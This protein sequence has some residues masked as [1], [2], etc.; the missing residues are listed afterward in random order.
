MFNEEAPEA[1]PVEGQEGREETPAQEET[2]E[3]EVQYNKEPYKFTSKDD[4]IAAAQKG[5]NYDK[6]L[7]QLTEAEKK[8]QF[9]DDL[10]KRNGFESFEAYQKAS[11]EYEQKKQV[12]DLVKQGIS[13]ELAQR[14]LQTETK[15]SEMEQKEQS[16]LK[17]EEDDRKIQE[18]VDEFPELDV[19]KI[20]PEVYVAADEKY[21]GD[22]VKA[23][24]KHER[25]TLPEQIEKQTLEKIK[26]NGVSSMG[27]VGEGAQH[28]PSSVSNMSDK[29]FQ[30]LKDRVKAGELVNL[31]N[32]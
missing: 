24:L 28:K 17:K 19:E 4:L 5:L 32:S 22:L 12:D 25:S 27:A 7:E 9:V 16:M 21:G 11:S 2:F 3:F 26:Q 20:P 30:S 23:Y 6:K 13:E 14:L 1:T 8:A 29:D 31:S 15:L 18:F 10:A